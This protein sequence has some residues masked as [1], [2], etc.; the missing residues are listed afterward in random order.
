MN[1]RFLLTFDD[2]PHANTERVLGE[3]ASNRVQRD[4]KA[5][6]FVQ[7]RNTGGG[8]CRNGR[9]M[10]Q[11]EHAEG[12]VLGLHTGTVRGHVSHTSMSSAD[13]G[14]SLADGM[15]DIRSITGKGPSLVRPPYWWFNPATV[16]Q[17]ERHGLRMMLS[18]VKAYDGIDCGLHLFRRWNFRAQLRKVHRSLVA[19]EIPSVGG[20]VPVVVAFH[21]TNRYTAGNLNAYLELLLEA[22]GRAGLCLDDKPYYD[23]APGMLKAA[24]QRAVL[25]LRTASSR[26]RPTEA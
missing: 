14:R 9:A 15:A 5:V 19:R 24:L 22:A 12:H 6:F 25:P 13:L 20:V 21:D 16:A 10:L 3:L 26:G 18:D 4:I 1:T 8:G 7:T 17:Y 2:G 11:K 23:E